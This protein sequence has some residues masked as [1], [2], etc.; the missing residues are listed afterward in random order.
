MTTQ[1]NQ[2]TTNPGS[3]DEAEQSFVYIATH[4]SEIIGYFNTQ[5]DASDA[6]DQYNMNNNVSIDDNVAIYQ[7]TQIQ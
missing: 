3:N 2:P 5:S 7:S 4:N 6:I 1:P